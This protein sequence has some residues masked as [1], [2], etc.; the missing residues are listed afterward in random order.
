MTDA[1]WAKIQHF[2][3]AAKERGE[4]VEV[5]SRQELLSPLEVAKRLGM[6]RT[7]VLRRIATGE[8]HASKVGT[9]H[10]V[11]LQELERYNREL[12]LRA[13]EPSADDIEAEL[14]GD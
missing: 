8:I 6:S 2:I 5:S 3:D 7:T 13:A 12:M 14:S 9:H 11:T 10:R 4:L 1:D